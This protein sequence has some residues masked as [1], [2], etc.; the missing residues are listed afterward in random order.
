MQILENIATFLGFT[1]IGAG[2]AALVVL[3]LFK[4]LGERW[5]NSKFEERLAAYKHAQLKELEELRFKIN[6]L[7]DRTTKLHQREFDVLP[8]A[9]GKLVVAYEHAK[10]FTALLRSYP[11]VNRMTNEQLEEF[12]ATIDIP[13]SEKKL[14]KSSDD[15][16]SIYQ[17]YAFR[18]DFHKSMMSWHEYHV[19]IRKNGIFIHL[20]MKDKFIEIGDLIWNALNEEKINHT[21]KP[22]PLLR[23][24][25]N[26]FA[27]EGERL[28]KALENDVQSRLWN[29][30]KLE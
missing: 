18:H 1:V 25:Y 16:I 2:S 15:R 12:L 3:G 8:E 10:G 26:K 24:H 22:R 21:H 11:D 27:G 4:W 20:E 5:L 17:Q 23:E 13:D 28:V 29:A 6:T 30:S 7:M 19:Y 9:W 14:L